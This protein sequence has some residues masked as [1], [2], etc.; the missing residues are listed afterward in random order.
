MYL[1][2]HELESVFFF[3][4]IIIIITHVQDLQLLHT[5]GT[6][7]LACPPEAE[8][9]FYE[10]HNHY[11]VHQGHSDHPRVSCPITIAVGACNDNSPMAL[12]KEMGV[13]QWQKFCHGRLERC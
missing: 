11:A 5:D 9:R 3:F 6:C 4:L 7:S 8:A 10:V 2:H 12:F 13:H 1:A